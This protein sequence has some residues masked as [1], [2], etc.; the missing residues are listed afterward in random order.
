MILDRDNWE[1]YDP[2]IYRGAPV[3]LQVMG[4]RLEEENM[5]SIAE[6][7]VKALDAT[8]KTL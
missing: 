5:L 2:E 4:Q 1:A 8:R 6:A 7:I 3:G